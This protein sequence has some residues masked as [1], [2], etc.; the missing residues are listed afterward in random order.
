M[1]KKLFVLG[2]GGLI[3]RQLV[4]EAVGA[5]YRVVGLVRTPAAAAQIQA[6][7][8]EPVIGEG[9]SPDPWIQKAR[10]A[11]AIVDLIQ[12]KLPRRLG[13]KQV[14]AILR[15]RMETTDALLAALKSLPEGE[16]PILFFQSGA[17]DLQPGEG[18][19]ISHLSRLRES[20]VGFSRLGVPLR[21]RIEASGLPATYTYFGCMVLGPGKALTDS[22]MPG[23][24]SGKFPLVQGGKTR[25]P[26]VHV[27]DAARALVHLAGLPAEKLKGKTFVAISEDPT[28][29]AELLNTVA[30]LEGAPKPGSVPKWLATLFAGSVAI[31]S[32]TVDA[33]ADATALRS[34]GFEFRYRSAKESLKPTLEAIKAGKHVM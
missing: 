12:P 34:E 25:L 1:S 31:E 28:S 3:G 30:E 33:R 5:G 32:Y 9:A 13:R 20:P 24:K 19:V 26:L 17:E 8:A 23:V 7:G 15:E 18:N 21:R 29:Q 4:A 27:K 14:E 10:G 6:L 16:R 22:I 2:A 11:K